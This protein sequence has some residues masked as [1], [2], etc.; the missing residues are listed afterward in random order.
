MSHVL[1]PYNW[2]EFIFHKGSVYNQVSITQSGLVAGGK[3][4][5]EGRQSVFFTPLGPFGSD[6]HEEEEPSEDYSKPRKVHYHC[7]WRNDQNAVYWVKLSLLDCNF[8]RHNQIPSFHI[9]QCH[10]NVLK[11]LSAETKVESYSKEF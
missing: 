10:I 1:I 3:E 7:Q 11:E 6:A 5:K 2:I 8:G 4:S 9:N